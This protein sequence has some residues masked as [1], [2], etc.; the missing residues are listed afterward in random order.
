MT[1][2]RRTPGELDVPPGVRADLRIEGPGLHGQLVGEGSELRLLLAE[3]AGSQV[4]RGHARAMAD[5]L[6]RLGVRLDVRDPRGRRLML[7]GA[8]VRS[9]FGR[10]LVGSSR[11]RPTVRAALA[12][13]LRR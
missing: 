1:A 8:G 11:A 12:R 3:G 2:T 5:E 4:P 13:V 9:W 7:A 10:F 6:G